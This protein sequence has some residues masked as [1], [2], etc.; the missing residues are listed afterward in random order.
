MKVSNEQDLDPRE[1]FPTSD[2]AFSHALSKEPQSLDVIANKFFRHTLPKHQILIFLSGDC[3]MNTDD[4]SHKLLPGD[5]C[6][7]PALSYY[8]VHIDG[9]MPYERVIIHLV[10]NERFDKLA[11]KIFNDTKPI[12]VNLKRLIPYIERYK[13][14]A[15]SLPMDEFSPFAHNLIEELL[16]ICLIEKNSVDYTADTAENL[17]KKVLA[18]IDE[19]WEKIKNVCDISN[20]LF[21][22]PSYLYEI[23][24]KKLNIAPKAYLMQKRMQAAH[25]YLISGVA[26]NETSQLVG[27]T[28]YTSFYRACKAFY[29]KT[30]QEIWVKAP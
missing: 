27:F 12:R 3:T 11:Y 9:N 28:T 18:Y 13:E 1:N 25:A 4:Y 2:L 24:S 6:F 10:P 21:I 16:Y 22:S 17:L 19:N 8:G 14:Y 7:N 29:V 23:F 15:K 30:P 20:A 5:V 26:P